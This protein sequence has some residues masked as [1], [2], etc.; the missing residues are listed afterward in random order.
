MPNYNKSPLNYIGGKYKILPQILEYFPQS[1]NNFID[2]FAGGLD[3][4]T[5]VSSKKTFCNDINFYTIQIYETMQEK[6]IDEILDY[7]D[8]KIEEFNLT[9]TNGEAYKKFRAYYNKTKNP[10]DLY[11]LVC[12][13]FNYQFRFN[14]KHEFNN[15]FGKDR[16]CF[17]PTIRDNLIKFHANIKDFIFSAENFKDYNISFLKKSD[18]LYAD[19]PYRI[20]VG[21]YNDGKRGFE[22]WS[23]EDDIILFNRLDDL[24]NG[25]V[26]FALSN[27]SEHKGLVNG[28]LTAWAKKYNVHR[29]EKNYNNS[30]YQVKD[31]SSITKEIL[32]TNY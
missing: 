21:S 18:F 15:P 32:V 28:E 20:T 10:L 19:P 2:L 29:I 22:G 14:S 5:N 16:S 7:I 26:K 25:G 23:K 17:N 4:A 9:K 1:I 31:K 8:N 6:S 30:S 13:S 24:H 12:Y 11:I 27:V 3:V